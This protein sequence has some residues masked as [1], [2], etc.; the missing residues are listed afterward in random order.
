MEWLDHVRRFFRGTPKEPGLEALVAAKEKSVEFP[1]LI[2]GNDP[3]TGEPITLRVGKFGPYLARGE[4]GSAVL[5]DVPADLA[6]ADLTV[7]RASEILNARRERPRVV[8]NDP[9]TGKPIYVMNGRFG[10]YVQ[11]GEAEEDSKQKP[12]RASL[13]AGMTPESVTLE[14]ALA[15]L[16]FPR[17]LGRH[18]ETGKPVIVNKGRFGPYVAHE[19]DF[20]SLKKSD[21]PTTITLARALELL[22]EPKVP[23]GA[24]R[25]GEREALREL[26]NAP[27]GEAVKLMDGRYGVYVTDGVRNATLPKEMAPDSLTLEAALALLE[28][29]G[30]V[31]KSK[32][33]AKAN[34]P[35][36]K[37][38]KAPA[39]ATAKAAKAAKKAKS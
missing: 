36:A 18:P 22:A 9:A 28:E 10:A 4:A 5:A 16:A 8:G 31:S 38:A 30:K 25:G 34:P 21:D 35:A 6:P 14:Q 26:G 11:L 27:G 33:K 24:A 1:D 12:P 7:E 32:A 23:R 2:L 13:E 29:R 19:K 3:G 15:L 20:R 17:E 37:A 39:K